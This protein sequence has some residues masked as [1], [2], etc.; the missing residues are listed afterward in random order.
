M[1]VVVDHEDEEEDENDHPEVFENLETR[2]LSDI[3]DAPSEI[4]SPATI[5][6]NID[7][8]IVKNKQD[9]ESKIKL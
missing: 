4:P 8:L 9:E 5:G 2:K 6:R 1:S 3:K 7:N